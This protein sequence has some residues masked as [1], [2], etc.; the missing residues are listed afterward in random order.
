MMFTFGRDVNIRMKH[1]I[2]ALCPDDQ[3]GKGGVSI[4]LW[5]WVPG[6]EEKEDSLM[7]LGANGEG[8][9]AK[10]DSKR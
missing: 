5:G 9:H 1:G 4:I 10:R 2:N 3:D 6:I 7:M 8:P